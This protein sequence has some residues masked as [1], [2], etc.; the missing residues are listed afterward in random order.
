MALAVRVALMA[1]GILAAAAGLGLHPEPSGAERVAAHRG[2]S[3]AHVDDAPHACPG[4]L[5]H[6]ASLT[7]PLPA[8]LCAGPP[9]S[10]LLPSLAAATP[11]RLAGRELSGRSPPARS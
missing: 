10:G 1:A 6:G 5:T 2:F 9:E 11:G 4:C 3:S 8:T 7:P